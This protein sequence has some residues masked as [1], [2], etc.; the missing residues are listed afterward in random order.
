MKRSGFLT[1]LAGAAMQGRSASVPRGSACSRRSRPSGPGSRAMRRAG[2][3]C[4]VALAIGATLVGPGSSA[5]A[6]AAGERITP[7][8][9]DAD[10]GKIA[11]AVAMITHKTIIMDPRVRAQVTIFSSTPMSPDAFYQ[12]FLD[13]LQVHGFMAVQQ[14]DIVKIMPDANERYMPGV[15]LTGRVSSTSDEIVTQ[16]MQVKNVSAAQLVPVL[17]PLIPPQGNLGA[18]PASNILIISDRA[19]NVNRIMRIVERIDESNTSDVDVMTM[20]NASA[21]EIARIVSSLYQGQS[22][23]ELGAAPLKIIA[24]ERSNS[25]LL[26]GDATA[27]L[28]AKALI[29][30][31]DTPLSNGGN[32]QVRYLHYEDAKKLAPLLKQQITGMTQGAG[33]QAGSAGAQPG[34]ETEIWADEPNN[35]LVITAPPKEMREVN[36]IIDKLD[37]RRAQVLVEAI[38]VDVDIDKNAELGVNWA[39]FSQGG[40]IPGATFLT[41]VGGA[42]LVDLASAIASSGQTL[43]SSGLVNGTTIAVG[44]LAKTGISFAAMLRALQSNDDSDIIATP[45]TVTLDH[46]EATIKIAQEVPFVTGQYTS[47]TTAIAGTVTPFETIQREE[48]G[49]ILKITPQINGSDAIILKIEIESSS[50]V[51]KNAGPQGAVDLTTNKRTVSTNVLIEDGGIIV[52]GGLISNEYDRTETGVPFFSRIPLLGELFK[53]H[54]ATHQKK[55]LMIF[56]RPQILRDGIDTSI[57]TDAKYNFIREQQRQVGSSELLPLLPG[58]KSSVLPPIPPP[59]ERQRNRAKPE[60]APPQ[61]SPQATPGTATPPAGA[62]APPEGRATPPAPASAPPAGGADATS[63]PAP[64][65]QS[66]PQGA[67]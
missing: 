13:I 34:H 35:A 10:I 49:T 48:V 55:N 36:A 22:Q 59:P 25:I 3:A 19:A 27:R 58:A 1:R 61:S 52:I 26:S 29:A 66:K 50:V 46:Q 44:R 23:S 7:N 28:R 40:T 32:T 65:P 8:F 20:Q 63:H 31:L 14:G 56:I 15:D 43:P 60:T 21:V 67:Q 41:P 33:G 64:E 57:E 9:T 5:F 37:I 30:H 11:E 2:F 39:T 12:T 16:V 42:S 24:D 4:T 17:R 54:T 62:V 18:Y 38:I 45:S 53:D 51:P 6:Q 47:G